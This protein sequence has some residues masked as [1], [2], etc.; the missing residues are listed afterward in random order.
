MSRRGCPR[1]VSDRT[2]QEIE[3]PNAG[4]SIVFKGVCS[5]GVSGCVA[6]PSG[7]FPR[8]TDVGIRAAVP[9]GSQPGIQEPENNF[10]T[11]SRSCMV[12]CDG[13]FCLLLS[14][15]LGSPP[16][17]SR[18]SFITPSYRGGGQHRCVK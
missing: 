13:G 17:R 8:A 18:R 1:G 10:S 7:A 16:P 4:L 14:G 15:E 5:V 11:L 12:V 3:A 9:D 6:S 2:G